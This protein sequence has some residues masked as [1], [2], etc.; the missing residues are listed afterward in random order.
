M[1]M[2]F[3]T[4]D[5]K[6]IDDGI[7]QKYAKVAITPEG[8]FQYPTGHAGLESLKYDQQILRSLPA[9]VLESFCGVGNP[10]SL[11]EIRLG[12]RILDIGCGGGLDTMVAAMMTGPEGSAVGIDMTSEMVER[13]KKNLGLA[14][15]D[16]VS[17]Q[18]SSAEDLPFP[19]HDFDAV[20]SNGVFN[21]VTD[22][23]KAL[24]EVLRVLKS[25]GRLTMA[26]QV[27]TCSLPGDVKTRVE[28]WAG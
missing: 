11:G 26:D 14:H 8:L 25:G 4:E 19:D 3:S 5:R 18:E 21:L 22:K 28:N 10:F 15:L 27:L 1:K 16:N 9:P 12:D 24:R 6:R 7:R 2:D 23:V 13:A 17:F 20:I